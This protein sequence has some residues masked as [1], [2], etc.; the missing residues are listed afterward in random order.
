MPMTIEERVEAT[1]RATIEK[2]K[3]N[4]LALCKA[5]NTTTEDVI[6]AW[7]V[8][9]TGINKYDN[10][11]YSSNAMR[12][13]MHLHNH[14]SG[15]WHDKRQAKVLDIIRHTKPQHIVE[16]GFGTPQR[17]VTEYVL[18]NEVFLQLLD[19]DEAALDFASTFLDTRSTKWASH[20]V[21][22]KYD[23][24]SMG[25]LDHADL[26]IFQ[27]SI[28]HTTDPSAYLRSVVSNAKKGSHFIFCLPIEVDKPVP[29]H[30][31]FWRTIDEA[32]AWIVCG[33]LV[34]V[35]S[36]EIHM[37]PALDLFAKF[38]HPDFKEIVVLAQ[39]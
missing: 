15:N 19:M 37:D 31:A 39:K 1:A 30:H 11:V 38:L 22:K 2:D 32:I 25:L 5:L 23:M 36:S 21:L 7:V 33:G 4:V 10:C 14:L 26:Y 3:K 34:V 29:E 28:E 8:W 20:I 12:I 27:D 16:V 35:E 9:D 6:K 13:A 24:N 18:K 17:Y